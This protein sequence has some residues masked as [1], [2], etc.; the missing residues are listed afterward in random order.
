VEKIILEPTSGNTGIGLAMVAAFKGY[1]V[2]L[3][4]SEGMSEERKKM[5][6][7]LGA[8]LVLTDKTQGTDGAIRKAH[9]LLAENPEKYWIPNQFANPAN[10]EAHYLTT[11]EEIMEDVPEI[12]HFVA[13]LGTSGTL[14]GASRKLRERKPGI[15]IIAVEP[16]LGHKLQGLKNMRESIVPQIFNPEIYDEKIT[17][18]D[19]SAHAVVR[20]IAKEE[21]IFLGMSSG[22]ALY[23]SLEL[24]KKIESGTIVM[25]APD[26]GEKYTS[27]ILFE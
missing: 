22:A 15:R 7:A 6:R 24:A 1:R 26:R 17:V 27:T 18:D 5:L 13:G 12:T 2:M 11:A 8:E 19:Q 25:V 20:R 14:T 4:M 21:G 23:A 16:L 3:T 9:E 10:P